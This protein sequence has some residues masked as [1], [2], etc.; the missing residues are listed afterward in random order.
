MTRPVTSTSV[1]TKG[2]ELVAWCSPTGFVRLYGPWS[3]RFRWINVPAEAL[4]ALYELY[5]TP[6][7][8][9]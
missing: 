9:A 7:A 3:S 2:A 5:P 4:E 6:A 1:A 8:H